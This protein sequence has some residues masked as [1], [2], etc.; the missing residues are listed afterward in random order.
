MTDEQN[1]ISEEHDYWMSFYENDEKVRKLADE[2]HNRR[3]LPPPACDDCI[4]A[5]AVRLKMEKA[6]KD[7]I[8]KEAIVNSFDAHKALQKQDVKRH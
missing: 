1:R 5:A 4:R 8:P 3:M 6:T 2:I 7:G